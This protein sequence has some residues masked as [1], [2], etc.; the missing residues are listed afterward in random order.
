MGCWALG[1]CQVRLIL[2]S[3]LKES[4]HLWRSVISISISLWSQNTNREYQQNVA[5]IIVQTEVLLCI[6]Y[7]SLINQPCRL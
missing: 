7:P 4:D 1:R 5:K 2:D 6:L 3:I